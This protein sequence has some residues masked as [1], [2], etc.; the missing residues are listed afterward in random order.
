M[1]AP[2]EAIVTKTDLSALQMELRA[3]EQKLEAK[4]ATTA[5]DLKVDILRWL[6]VTQLALGGFLFAAMKF[7][8]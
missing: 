6:I 3:F 2:T 1:R 5:A 4:I 7:T 8:R